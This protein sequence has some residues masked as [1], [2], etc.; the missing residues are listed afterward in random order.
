MRVF[1]TTWRKIWRRRQTIYW[2]INI[3]YINMLV[4][5]RIGELVLIWIKIK[6][7]VRYCH[8]KFAGEKQTYEWRSTTTNN[9]TCYS[10]FAVV[11]D[12]F[13]YKRQQQLAT[14][15]EFTFVFW[16]SCFDF[17]NID[18]NQRKTLFVFKIEETIFKLLI[19]KTKIN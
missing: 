16:W 12:R 18:D 8:A 14:F 2:L 3:L 4:T 15:D 6:S 10:F 13:F 11:F 17:V 1:I 7:F 19:Y 9:E 5:L